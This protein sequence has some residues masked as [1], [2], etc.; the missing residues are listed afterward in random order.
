MKNNYIQA[1]S[2]Y[3]MHCLTN[4]YKYACKALETEKDLLTDSELTDLYR[5]VSEMEFTRIKRNS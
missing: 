1:L 5:I 3:N 4:A 2:H